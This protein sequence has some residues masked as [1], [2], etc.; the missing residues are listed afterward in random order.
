[1]RLTFLEGK[2]F[3]RLNA[4]NNMKTRI[5]KNWDSFRCQIILVESPIACSILIY[6][7]TLNKN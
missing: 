4:L 6:F 3:L 2:L 1:M 5:W 7:D